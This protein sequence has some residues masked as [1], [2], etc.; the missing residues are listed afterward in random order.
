[1]T[2]Y[3]GR[4]AHIY[5]L[6]FAIIVKYFLDQKQI[7]PKD[8]SKPKAEAFRHMIDEIFYALPEDYKNLKFKETNGGRKVL[9]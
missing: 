5:D 1:M 2:F 6:R 8:P 3:T 9:A 4:D 7:N